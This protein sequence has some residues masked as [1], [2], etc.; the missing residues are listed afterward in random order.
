L[1]GANPWQEGM[2][3]GPG[4]RVLDPEGR[5]TYIFTGIVP[6]THH[7]PLFFPGAAGVFHWAIVPDMH[8][9]YRVYPDIEGIIVA[10]RHDEIWWN[11]DLTQ[12]YRWNSVDNN[13]VVWPPG[14]AG[15]H[16][17]EAVE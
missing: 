12:R 6:M 4:D 9:G 1:T 7:N 8:Q 15:V 5:Y 17:W 13:A 11:T 14:T 10:V 16:Q 3:T 2:T